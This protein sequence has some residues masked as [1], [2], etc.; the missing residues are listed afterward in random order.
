MPAFTVTSVDTT[1]NTLTATA[2]G[3]LTGDR[4]RLR[5]VGGALPAATPS[6][7]GVT[8]Y[9]ALRVDA[10][11]LKVCDTNA[12][13]LAGTGIVD[14]TGSGSGTT[15]IEYGLPFC[16]PN[17]IAVDG[18]SQVHAKDLNG[19]WNSLVALWD[20]LS[21]QPQTIWNHSVP[22]LV[23]GC[24]FQINAGAPTRAGQVWTFTSGGTYEV[25]A[26]LQL[27]PAARI[28]KVEF[29]YNRNGSTGAFNFKLSKRSFGN[30]GS[31]SGD[32]YSDSVSTGTGWT[33]HDSAAGVPYATETNML[34]LLSVGV[35]VPSANALFDGARVTLDRLS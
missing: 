31:T 6:L 23:P 13:A 17:E 11:T 24:L 15:T 32:V 35:P 2:H 5:N 3:L 1:A 29:S 34:Y 30:G 18:V 7:A 10:D 28:T 19:T 26:P 27:P 22:V 4:F 8:D 14:L 25:I 9:F 33:T 20:L 21:G 16:I 12:H